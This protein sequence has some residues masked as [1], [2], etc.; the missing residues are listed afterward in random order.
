VW[1][2]RERFLWTLSVASGSG[3]KLQYAVLCLRLISELLDIRIVLNQG[4]RV[5]LSY[6][7]NYKT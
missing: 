5:E 2:Y 7:R 6:E 4:L 3:L 1:A